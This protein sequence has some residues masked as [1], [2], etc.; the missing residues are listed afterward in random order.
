MPPVKR[1]SR[2]HKAP[3]PIF[4]HKGDEAGSK[5]ERQTASY[6]NCSFQLRLLC[7]CSFSKLARSG[8]GLLDLHMSRHQLRSPK[9]GEGRAQGTTCSVDGG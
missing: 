5:Q 4:R 3:S 2:A 1:Q 6:L 8:A 9:A 7:I